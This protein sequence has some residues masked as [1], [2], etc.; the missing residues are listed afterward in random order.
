MDLIMTGWGAT[1]LICI[2][3]KADLDRNR[4]DV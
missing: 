1:S 4:H 3:L 2:F